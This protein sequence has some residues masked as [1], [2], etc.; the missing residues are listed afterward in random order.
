[1]SKNPLDEIAWDWGTRC[2][3]VVHMD[4]VPIRALRMIEE[5]IELAQACGVDQEQLHKLVD[6][7]YSRKSGNVNQ[8]V[9]GAYLTLRML[10][11]TLRLDIEGEYLREIRRCLS[12][13][14]ADFT[15]RNEDKIQLG[16][17]T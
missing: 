5:S 11:R 13:D 14:P 12:K 9:G 15:A 10:C 7:V 2:F 6:I 17:K 16:L 8:E 4:Y 1:M 3:G